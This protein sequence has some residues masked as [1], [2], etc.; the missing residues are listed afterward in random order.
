MTDTG[1]IYTDSFE[2]NLSS[3]AS[4]TIT[5]A[6]S[7][8]LYSTPYLIPKIENILYTKVS[9][10]NAQ[11][12][13]SFYIINGNN[14]F[15]STSL[16]NFIFTNGNYNALTFAT[17]AKVIL[18][19]TWNIL[20]N[21]STGKFTVSNTL[22]EFSIFYASTCY[23]ILG[24]KTGTNYNSTGRSLGMPLPCN[25]LGITKL[26]LMS[27]SLKSQNLDIVSRGNFLGTIPVNSN[28][29]GLIQYNNP[30]NDGFILKNQGVDTIDIS[31]T[32]DDGRL[33]DF[34]GIHL[35]MTLRFDVYKTH[36]QT[37]R[38]L[39]DFVGLGNDGNIPEPPT[40]P[41]K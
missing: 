28:I 36:I 20:F 1:H 32:D 41:T 13:V 15:L 18:G 23:R 9:V 12:P 7:Q 39:F 34:N 22:S 30:S 4:L 19:A 5:N 21:Q 24:L 14:N 2:I 31:I 11:I 37:Q 26:N 3:S 17:M 35:T 33:V 40:P 10:S 27:N 25:F 8:L 29:Y 6:N 38:G 16:G